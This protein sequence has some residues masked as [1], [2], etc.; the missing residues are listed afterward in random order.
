[1]FATF[2]V[3]IRTYE[4][5]KY[6]S[7]A[8][9]RA[10]AETH[11]FVAILHRYVDQFA[12]GVEANL[13]IIASRA[14]SA[15]GIDDVTVPWNQ[16]LTRFATFTSDIID[17]DVVDNNGIV[18]YS[19]S[20]VRVGKPF[21][22]PDIIEQ[23]KN[24]PG[25]VL[26]PLKCGNCSPTVPLMAAKR[27]RGPNGQAFGAVVAVVSPFRI[28]S[29]AT[30]LGQSF[31]GTGRVLLS[32]GKRIVSHTLTDDDEFHLDAGLLERTGRIVVM[33]WD[34]DPHYLFAYKYLDNLHLFVVFQRSKKDILAAWEGTF[35]NSVLIGL[36]TVGVCIGASIFFLSLLKA[37]ERIEDHANEKRAELESIQSASKIAAFRWYPSRRQLA[38]LT[39]GDFV[40]RMGASEQPT[41]LKQLLSVFPTAEASRLKQ[42]IEDCLETGAEHRLELTAARKPEEK[43]APT[44]AITTFRHTDAGAGTI[45]GRHAFIVC[46]DISEW[47]ETR[48]QYA[49]LLKM[50]AVGK[51]TGGVAHDFNNLLVVILG[52]IEELAGE[53]DKNDPR[54][55]LLDVTMG[56]AMQAR[57]LT[58]RLLAFARKQPLHP[59]SIDVSALINNMRTLLK[60]AVG[61]RVVLAF[62][63]QIG[64][65][66]WKVRADRSQLEIAILNLVINAR[67][68]IDKD[69]TITIRARRRIVEESDIV[70]HEDGLVPGDY[71]DVMVEDNGSGIAPDAVSR[72]IEPYFTTKPAGAGAGLGLSQVYGFVNQS[73]GYFRIHSEPGRG[74]L[75]HM[76]LPRDTGNVSAPPQTDDPAD[77]EF[78]NETILVVEDD[79]AVRGHAE[80]VLTSLG[81][82][83]IS[84]IDGKSAIKLIEEGVSFDLV[85]TDVVLPGGVSGVDV[86]R[87]LREFK[88]EIPF[89]FMSGYPSDM[90]DEAGRLQ[91]EVLFVQKPFLRG[92]LAQKV[93]AALGAT[94]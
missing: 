10:Q 33:P 71:V 62:D 6:R 32:D 48:T 34:S 79:E 82:K 16:M 1:L 22:D 49:H 24:A 23:A 21:P 45:L 85:L 5:I 35:W 57:E 29:L 7:E 94:I 14:E 38:C 65:E 76:Y 83:V 87:H 81:Y 84:R 59:T 47:H 67:D 31:S 77:L 80:R 70:G 2:V 18:W 93:R 30:L 89:L 41:Q 88:P 60:R 39:G 20:T 15:S 40:E 50:D 17:M 56:A 42:A 63:N 55:A 12:A 86:V 27:M 90:L 52:N 58:K 61:E 36:L 54:Y 91:D 13:E 19:S 92:E 64:E 78:G 26:A 9:I 72:V 25:V 75:V 69:G 8:R 74:T 11:A 68:A 53:Y 44:Y 43:A 37:Q 3:G 4:I 51:I 28:Q 46:Q 73:G 66:P